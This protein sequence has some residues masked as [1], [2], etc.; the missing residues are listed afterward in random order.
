MKSYAD[1]Y[2]TVTERG[3]VPKVQTSERG[4]FYVLQFMSG[5]FVILSTRAVTERASQRLYTLNYLLGG[6]WLNHVL[7]SKLGPTTHG[8]LSKY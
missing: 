4:M 5:D 7:R 1:Y 2:P 6:F 3:A 8:N